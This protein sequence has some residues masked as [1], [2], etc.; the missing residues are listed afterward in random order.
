MTEITAQQAAR[1]KR[2]R[3][4]VGDAWTCRVDCVDISEDQQM[5]FFFDPRGTMGRRV[6][7]LLSLLRILYAIIAIIVSMVVDVLFMIN[8]PLT[9]ASF[10]EALKASAGSTTYS[11]LAS[12]SL[13]SFA[14]F[15]PSVMAEFLLPALGCD[16]DHS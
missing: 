7:F 5:L 6:F 8:G 3:Q 4:L 11:A 14:L 16:Q 12:A 13:L 1:E 10:L 15:I 2:M 9:Q